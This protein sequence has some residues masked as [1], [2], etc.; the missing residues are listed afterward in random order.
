MR[1]VVERAER[2]TEEKEESRVRKSES[3][4]AKWQVDDDL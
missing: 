2:E 1:G 3:V 4:C